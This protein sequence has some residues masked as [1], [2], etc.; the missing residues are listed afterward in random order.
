MHCAAMTNVST[1]RE[2]KEQHLLM[3]KEIQDGATSAGDKLNVALGEAIHLAFVARPQL[4]PRRRST[5]RN[6]TIRP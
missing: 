3:L 5:M 1:T 4:V 2:F 6:V